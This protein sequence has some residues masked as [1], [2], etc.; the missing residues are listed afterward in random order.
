[1]NTPDLLSLIRE[2]SAEQVKAF[3]SEARNVSDD[4]LA[5]GL[6]AAVKRGDDEIVRVLLEAGAAPNRLPKESW[7]A[8]FSA[9]EHERESLIRLL[10]Q[11][12]ADINIRLPSG[13]TPLHHAVDTDCDTALQMEVSPTFALTK[14]LLSL[15]ADPRQKDEQGE[16][17]IDLARRYQQDALVQLL[18][19]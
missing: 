14:L 12:G 9:I 13:Y 18:Q 8:L 6:T 1:M 17:P 4:A 10:V 16:S 7:P 15:G 11:G 19:S 3:V 2:G 5:E